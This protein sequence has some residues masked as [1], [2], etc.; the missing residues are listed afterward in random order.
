MYVTVT[1]QTGAGEPVVLVPR[2]AVQSIGERTVVYVPVEGDAGR[3]QERA[4]KL[5][6]P[7]GESFQ[8]LEGLTPG[9]RVVTEGAF[10]L[11]EEATR[12]RSGG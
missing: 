8:A 10:F 1:F 12:T 6:P 2:A 5:G 3:F 7:M 9:E 4:V 11:R